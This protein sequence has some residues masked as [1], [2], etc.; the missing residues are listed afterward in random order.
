MICEGSSTKS[1]GG[2]VALVAPLREDGVE[3]VPELVEEGLHLLLGEQRRRVAGRAG[4][5]A[6]VGD[7]GADLLAVLHP[8]CRGAAGPGPPALARPRVVVD[9]ED[10]EV[11]AVA[12]PSP[13]RPAP[14]GPSAGSP[15]L[16]EGDAVEA[17]RD[18][19]GAL[20]HPVEGEVGAAAR[21]RRGRS[22]A[23]APSPCSRTSPRARGGGPSRPLRMA[24]SRSPASRAAAA[25]AGA[26]SRSTNA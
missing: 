15:E 24:S 9:E 10:G 18:A 12:R 26:H 19:E 23:G 2:A 1:R 3:A 5:V 6:G 7:D 20:A 22:A 25:L 14:P 13:R 8:L 21:S 4:E 17:V 16:G 11:G